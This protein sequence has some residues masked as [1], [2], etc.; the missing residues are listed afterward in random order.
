MRPSTISLTAKT[1]HYC[2]AGAM[3]MVA[4]AVASSFVGKYPLSVDKLLAGDALQW[5]VFLT[6]RLSRT[7]V[8]VIGGAALGVAGL[9]YQTVFRNPLASPD[10]IGV[11]SG[12]SAGAAAGILFLSGATAVTVSAFAGALLAVIF[13]LALSGLD[14]SGRNSTIVLAGIA[15]HSL[16]QT[17]LMCLK[18]T[19][20]PE[21]ELAS[22]EYWIMGSLNGISVYSIGGNLILCVLGMIALFLL[23]RQV[24]LLSA[25]EGEARMLGVDVGRLRLAVLLIATLVVSAVVSLTG[26]ISFVGLLAP[27]GARL[28]TKHDRIG[29]MLLSGFLGGILLCGADILARTVAATEL[30]VSIFTSILGAPFLIFLIVRGR[31]QL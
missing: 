22:I 13:A 14:R 3:L 2:T 15:V 18:L 26:L 24:V 19:A 29:T 8:G 12:A 7:V 25:E 23:Q 4:L 9:V 28:L 1:K 27:H 21:R 31:R 16:A 20:D 5:R 6:L 30:P 11:S 17:V 10:I